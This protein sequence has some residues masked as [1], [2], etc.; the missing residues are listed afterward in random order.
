MY[1]FTQNGMIIRLSDNACIPDDINNSDYMQ[2]CEWVNK[3]GKTL[4]YVEPQEV[5]EA[6]ERAWRNTELSRADIELNKVQDGM[7]GGTVTS[8]RE[9]RCALRN[10][11]A[12][13]DFPDS[14]KRPI[15]PDA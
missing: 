10:W 5:V 6:K 4:P 12:N 9:Y 7:G 8:W 2:Y 14:T 11:P 13:Q 15:A 1:Q 3:G